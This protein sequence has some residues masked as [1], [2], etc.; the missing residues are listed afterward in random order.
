LK[1]I[2]K[3]NKKLLTPT[4]SQ[5]LIAPS[6]QIAQSVEQ[7]T[8]NPCVP[9][10]ILGLATIIKHKFGSFPF[11]GALYQAHNTLI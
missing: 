2:T 6:G 3:I 7:R 9:S 1:D 5:R 8:E 4:H 10:S 11:V